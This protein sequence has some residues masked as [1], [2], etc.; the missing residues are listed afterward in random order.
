MT[1]VFCHI[2]ITLSVCKGNSVWDNVSAIYAFFTELLDKFRKTSIFSKAKIRGGHS[3]KRPGISLW[4]TV[5]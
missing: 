5:L 1:I 4:T 2:R 3:N